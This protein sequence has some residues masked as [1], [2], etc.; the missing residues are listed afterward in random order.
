M[1][2]EEY[3]RG[4]K[5]ASIV[6][7][8]RNRSN[9]MGRNQMLF[10][11]GVHPAFFN[12]R[13]MVERAIENIEANFDFIM[14]AEYFDE[15]VV[16]LRHILCWDLD[17]VIS[18]TIN[19]RMGS[20]K[21]NLTQEAYRNLE[22]WNWGDKLLY[23]YFL[24]KFQETVNEFGK[25][26]LNAEVQELRMR[27]NEWFE[28]CVEKK[29]EAKNLT[30]Y[31]IWSNKVAGY[32]LKNN[33]QNTTCEDLVKPENYFTS[34]IRQHQ[35]IESIT[36]GATISNYGPMSFRRLIDLKM[37]KGKEQ[38]IARNILMNQYKYRRRKFPRIK[39]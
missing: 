20:Y 13:A 15:S 29:V 2:I 31:N 9:A 36:K 18:L 34:E 27:R 14:V 32:V 37:L 21:K 8:L 1:D 28:H 30:S 33:I 7:K 4:T 12:N 5:N 25:E 22:E 26:R 38:G 6:P 11:F 10:D 24:K 3:A 39:E 16:L 17:D 19:A 23:D 35:L